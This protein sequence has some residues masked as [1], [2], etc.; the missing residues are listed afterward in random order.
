MQVHP[1]RYGRN[2]E[3]QHLDTDEWFS[4]PTVIRPLWRWHPPVQ[5][6]YQKSGKKEK[7]SVSNSNYLKEYRVNNI[8]RFDIVINMLKYRSLPY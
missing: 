8:D 5:Q 7:L 6:Q 2:R 3:R 4:V 1:S